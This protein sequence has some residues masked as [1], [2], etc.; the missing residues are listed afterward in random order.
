MWVRL[1]HTTESDFPLTSERRVNSVI[2]ENIQFLH[3]DIHT[4]PLSWMVWTQ[5]CQKVHLS[6]KMVSFSLNL[7]RC[8][9]IQPSSYSF[10]STRMTF[11]LFH[12]NSDIW[13]QQWGLSVGLPTVMGEVKVDLHGVWSSPE[14]LGN[15]PWPPIGSQPSRIAYR[16]YRWRNV[17]SSLLAWAGY[18]ELP[19]RQLIPSW[20]L[21]SLSA[22]SRPNSDIASSL[23][24]STGLLTP[25]WFIHDNS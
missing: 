20:V 16:S 6:G 12:L 3:S 4:K 25:N 11:L 17:W 19:R 8:Y 10:L 23:L 21:T 7:K 15:V 5:Q 13:I 22:P 9:F 24:L 1:S 18:H 2:L 14:S